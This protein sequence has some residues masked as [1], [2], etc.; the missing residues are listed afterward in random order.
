MT[1]VNKVFIVL[2]NRE[3][4]FWYSYYA[5]T[6][7]VWLWLIQETSEAKARPVVAKLQ[8]VNYCLYVL[9]I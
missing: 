5:S 3:R 6:W 8:E 2:F 9:F 7:D 1:E 4:V